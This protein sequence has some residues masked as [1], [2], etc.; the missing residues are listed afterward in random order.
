MA[1]AADCCANIESEQLRSRTLSDV[2]RLMRFT[3]ILLLRPISASIHKIGKRRQ[4]ETSI[5]K[6]FF[7]GNVFHEV[8]RQTA[9][10][11]ACVDL[12]RNAPL[13]RKIGNGR[14]KTTARNLR[15]SMDT[16]RRPRSDVP[17]EQATLRL[18]QQRA[19]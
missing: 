16:D 5:Q 8:Q 10:V 12:N 1:F 6:I 3:V 15:A 17:S 4:I 13:L 7:A 9:P 2:Q 18:A 14:E 19:P 11:V